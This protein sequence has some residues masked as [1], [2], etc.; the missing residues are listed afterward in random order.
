MHNDYTRI[1]CCQIQINACT[2]ETNKKQWTK[3]KINISV[4]WKL[5]NPDALSPEQITAEKRSW[6]EWSDEAVSDEGRLILHLSWY[7]VGHLL[8]SSHL[9]TAK[10][11]QADSS[12][13]RRCR[14]R[15]P[16]CLG[17]LPPSNLPCRHARPLRIRGRLT[18]QTTVL[19]SCLDGRLNEEKRKALTKRKIS[20]TWREG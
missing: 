15:C 5:I 17:P 20:E 19:G 13:I 8:V 16:S 7:N 9:Y 6:V 12:G 11:K 10:G 3:T 14:G 18:S 4:W 1:N 2:K